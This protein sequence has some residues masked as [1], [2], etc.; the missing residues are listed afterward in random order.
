MMDSF[1]IFILIKNLTDNSAEMKEILT[2][3]ED[4]AIKF[5]NGATKSIEI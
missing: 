1:T 5:F 4:E 2:T 3:D